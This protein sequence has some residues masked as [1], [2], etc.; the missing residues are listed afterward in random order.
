MKIQKS[1]IAASALIAL[2]ALTGCQSNSEYTSYPHVG[3]KTQNVLGIVKTTHESFEPAEQASIKLSAS[4]FGPMYNPSGT[5]T[6]LLW[7]LITLTDY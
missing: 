4:E 5:K 6:E 3:H 2:G 1:L 7:G